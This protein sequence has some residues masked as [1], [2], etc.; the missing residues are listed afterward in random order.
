MSGLEDSAE[1]AMPHVLIY[2]ASGRLGSKIVDEALFR[3]YQ[4]T[5]V[6]RDAAR[7][8]QRAEEISI[9]VSDILDREATAKLIR[10]YDVVIVSVGGPPTDSNPMNYIAARAAATLVDV[11]TPMG[12]S[13]PRFIFVGN[14]YT[15]EFE[16]GKTPLELGRVPESHRNYTMFH[17]HQMALDKFRHSENINWTVATPPNGLRLSGRTGRVRWG[18]NSILRDADGTPSTISPEDFAFAVIEEAK[19]GRYVQKRFTVAR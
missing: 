6:T 19:N 1:S 13:G 15:L 7:L 3:G 14:L 8:S 5:G 18:E 10:E 4:V 16:D 17:G 12:R 11:L 9:V 2:G